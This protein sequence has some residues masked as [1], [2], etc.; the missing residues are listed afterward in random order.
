MRSLLTGVIWGFSAIGIVSSFVYVYAI[1]VE[2]N[3][4][5]PQHT[6]TVVGSSGD[7]KCTT[8]SCVVKENGR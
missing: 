8:T 1:Y 6:S 7:L 2:V 3:M 5:T 4:K